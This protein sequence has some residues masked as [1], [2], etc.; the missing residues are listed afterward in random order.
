MK[1]IAII[2]ENK[3]KFF[4]FNFVVYMNIRSFKKKFIYLIIHENFSE[5]LCVCIE[6]NE[7]YYMIYLFFGRKSRKRSAK[8]KS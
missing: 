3:R 1:L 2:G 7:L 6:Y 5:N 4:V 8:I